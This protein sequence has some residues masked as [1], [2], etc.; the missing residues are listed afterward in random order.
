[1]LPYSPINFQGEFTQARLGFC[2][3]QIRDRFGTASGQLRNE[4]LA[5]ITICEAGPKQVAIRLELVG[6]K[7][8]RRERKRF[9]TGCHPEP[10]RRIFHHHSFTM[11]LPRWAIPKLRDSFFIFCF[12]SYNT[13]FLYLH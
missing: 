4:A 13:L 8:E 2:S 5:T 12:F 7:S 9:A 6:R 1:M 3:R 11:R 10:R